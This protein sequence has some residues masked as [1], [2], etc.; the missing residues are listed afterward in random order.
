[1]VLIMQ[2]MHYHK[3]STIEEA[4]DLLDAGGNRAALIAG[5]TDVMVMIKKHR[6]AP[7]TLVS[8]RGIPALHGLRY[9]GDALCIGAAT[10]HRTIEQS[11]LIRQ[12]FTALTDAVDVLGAVQIRNVGTIGG[13]ICTAAP[14]ADTAPPLLALGARV[15]TARRAGG[16]TI[17]LEDFFTGPR[18]T[19]LEEGEI[20]TALAVPNPLPF[21]ASAYW[22]HQRRRAL[23]IPI[24]GVAVSLSLDTDA[25]S[26]PVDLYS[27]EPIAVQFQ[28]LEKDRLLCREV[29]IALG[30]AAPTPMRALRAE[31]LLTGR[32]IG[33]EI[34]DAVA[35]TA[36][37][38]ARTRDSFRGEAWYRREMIRV[39]VQ[40]MVLLCIARIAG[41]M[42]AQGDR[43]RCGRP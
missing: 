30:V 6:M 12:T 21:T 33:S 42:Q 29:R 13:N 1:M 38:E 24:L 36:A 43:Q 14:S 35:R 10:T 23:D 31:Q 25:V 32:M 19:A 27:T 3:P 37:D 40:R 16:R 17:A 20:V 5:G 39:F 8:L 2:T 18:A 4:L 15:Q 41:Q 26:R 9:G 22:K 7:D 11:P 28:A 34:M